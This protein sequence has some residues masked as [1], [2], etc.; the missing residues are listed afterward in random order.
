M[1]D[2]ASL[3]LS[4]VPTSTAATSTPNSVSVNYTFCAVFN[5]SFVKPPY[6]DYPNNFHRAVYPSE[7]KL[8]CSSPINYN[9]SIVKP[10]VILDRGGCTFYEKARA[11]QERDASMVVVVYNST[12]MAVPDLKPNASDP[13]ISI[14]VLII[15]NDSGQQLKVMLFLK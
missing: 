1:S 9:S 14:P 4:T 11:S 15:G 7:N 3:A 10:S 2:F 13:S 6:Q 5:P 8:G 12:S